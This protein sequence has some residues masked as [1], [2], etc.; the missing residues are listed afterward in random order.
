MRSILA[1]LARRGVGPGLLLVVGSEFGAPGGRPGP[2]SLLLVPEAARVT[3]VSVGP[4]PAGVPAGVVHA[5]GG[6]RGLL[7]LLD[8]QLRRHDRQ[9]VPAIDDDP[10]WI[11]CENRGRAAAPARDRVAVHAGRGGR[12]DARV[13]GGGGSGCAADGTGGRGVRRDG[14]RSASAAGPVWTGLAVEPAPAGDR[15]ML[16]MRTGVLERTE[17]AGDACPLRTVRLASITVPRG[18]RHA[19]GGAGRP[20]AAAGPPAAAAAGASAGRRPGGRHVLGAGRR[21]HAGPASPPWRSSGAAAT[22]ACAPCS[23]WPPTLAAGWPPARSGCG[24]RGAAGGGG[25]G[26]RTTAGRPARGMGAPVGCR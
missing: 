25:R 22:A 12:G 14:F 11:V 19:R 23:G 24:G 6:C 20:A 26:L 8:E 15:R 9:R 2:D 17:L 7:A 3:A 21:R 5:G 1:V 10:A 16:D 4:E 13:G 18:G